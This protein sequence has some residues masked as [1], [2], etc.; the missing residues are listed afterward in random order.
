MRQHLHAA[1]P[2]AEEL[3]S[4]APQNTI[5]IEI[6]STQSKVVVSDV[7]DV[8]LVVRGPPTGPDGLQS[9]VLQRTAAQRD[10]W[11]AEITI[12]GVPDQV[13]L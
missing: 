7:P 5:Q 3:W 4:C 9:A 10:R 11:R 12:D 1:A 13:Y 6:S 8:V 2:P